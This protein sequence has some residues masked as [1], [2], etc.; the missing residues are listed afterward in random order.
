MI[1]YYIMDPMCSWCWGFRETFNELKTGLP[2]RIEVRYV[3]GGLAP[4]SDLPMPEDTV[5]YVQSQ[6][7]AVE[8]STGASFNWDFWTKCQPQRSTYPACRAVIAAGVQ[9]SGYI[10]DMIE[11]IQRAY[12]EQ[13]RNP[14]NTSTLIDLADDIGLDVGRF[15][16]DIDSNHVAK[17]LKAHFKTRDS[18]SAK[19]FPSL[20]LASDIVINEI[21]IDYLNAQG[22]LEQI[23]SLSS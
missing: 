7:K 8:E 23:Q 16:R 11:A 12:Y 17:M 9:Y 19:S 20:R 14:S 21:D 1:L 5:K 15:A 22:I 3:M 10:P 13:A 2:A 4:D 6:W 18:L